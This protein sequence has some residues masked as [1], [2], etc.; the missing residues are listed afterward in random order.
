MVKQKKSDLAFAAQIRA[1]RQLA[2]KTQRQLSDAAQVS[3][4]TIEAIEGNRSNP[5]PATRAAI[6]RALGDWGVRLKDNGEVGALIDRA[7]LEAAEDP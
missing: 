7:R 6:V 5:I 2:N 4:S 1:G 3:L